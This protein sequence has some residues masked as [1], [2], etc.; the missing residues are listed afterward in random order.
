MFVLDR[1]IGAVL[2]HYFFA[3]KNGFDYRTNYVMNTAKPDVL[4]FGSSRA[5]YHYNTK[6]L[7]DSLKISVYNAGRDLS[8]IQYHYALLQGVLKRYSPKL[9]VLDTRPNEFQKFENG[10]NYDR[11]NVLLPYYDTHPEIREVVELRSPYEKVKLLSKIY[12]YN[13][14]IL[15]ELVELLPIARYKKDDSE[16]GYIVKN[17]NFN[18]PR[19]PY[20]VDDEVDPVAALYYKK[21]VQVCKAK[22]IKLVIAYS[23][24]YQNI[25][26]LR[27]RNLLFAKQV[28]KEN[29][30][31]LI[32]YLYDPQFN[33][34]Q[35]FYDKLHLNGAGS[36]LYSQRIV[37]R[38][39]EVLNSK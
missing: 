22:N 7:Q 3:K 9:I 14:L 29:N 34:P 13:S 18:S 32:D 16:N 24:M 1:S 15:S 37:R 39:R 38:L 25:D 11:L 33:T 27:N 28:C 5:S 35:Y 30:L 36:T 31:P 21:F 17:G 20:T 12:P 26:T 23:P 6:V 2:Q 8:Y 4:I 10:E 19:G